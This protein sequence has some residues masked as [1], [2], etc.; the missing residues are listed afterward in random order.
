VPPSRIAAFLEAA[1]A[2]IRAVLDTARSYPFGHVG[3]GNLH[4]AIKA[5]GD[6][7]ALLAARAALERVVQEQTAKLGG[8]ISAEHGLG[9]AK[10]ED[11]LR[12]KSG[13]EIE[14]MR[15]LKRTLDPKNILNPGKLL[16]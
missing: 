7:A 13:A 12:Y 2:G 4:Y 1:D 11:I 15:A 16:P 9:L 10:S 6:E 5:P 14:L 8:S 3:D